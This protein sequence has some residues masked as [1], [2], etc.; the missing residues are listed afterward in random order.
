MIAFT[1]HIRT[2]NPAYTKYCDHQHL[3]EENF[4]RAEIIYGRYGLT[5]ESD[6]PYILVTYLLS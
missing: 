4:S 5:P 3:P 1:L 2:V 6:S